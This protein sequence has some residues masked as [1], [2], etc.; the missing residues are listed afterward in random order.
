MDV[1]ELRNR[2]IGD[3]RDYVESFM[4]IR[5]ERIRERVDL[6]LTQGALWPEPRIGLN[7]AF[8]PG[9]TVDELVAEGLLHPDSAKAFQVG[10][11]AANPFG[12]PI[13]FHRHQ[14]AA[15]REARAGHNYVLTTGTGSGKSLSY[16]VPIVDHVLREGSGGGIKAVVV[17]P[18]NALANSQLGELEKF[19]TFGF[20][21][22]NQP[23]TFR[24]YT[25][26][27]NE[28]ERSEILRDPPDILLTNYVMLELIL[29]R[30]YDRRLVDA[31]RE[32]RF[33]VFDE[34]HT[35]RGRQGADVA[36]LIRR[37]RKASGSRHIQYVGTSA[38]LSSEGT[39]AQQRQAIS[40]MASQLF[41]A[42]V[43][44]SSVIGETL[45]R[46][47]EP[48]DPGDAGFVRALRQRVASGD[49][50]PE[51]PVDFIAD[52][53]SRWIESTVG[54]EE[55]EGRLVRVTP[56]AIRGTCGAAKELSQL[57]DVDEERCA[58]AIEQQLM[59]G[60]HVQRR[61]FPVF[62]FRLHQFISR[63]DTVHA[64][65]EAGAIR[66]LT[67]NP[68]RFVPGHRD[69]ILLPLAFLPSVRPGLLR[70]RTRPA[71]RPDDPGRGR[72]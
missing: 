12:T 58:T 45:V 63:G 59:T 55:L 4:R 50:P 11:R 29:T 24:R 70:R 54:V 68:Q 20:P 31:M 30:V 16:I 46:V 13:E 72:H 5:D 9:G 51:Q 49:P 8:E 37:V 17:Y 23:A 36:L 44:P 33:L 15:I 53:L 38:T 19:L 52:P 10:K 48:G 1:F 65:P 43:K 47:T 18:M 21:T 56:R 26:Q 22:G 14:V 57:I 35:Y 32:L 66:H 25:G 62:A 71:R 42:E 34:L 41:G 28:E 69:R 2:L 60:Y 27:E 61:G 67:P 39:L 64:S 40:D 3:Y 6:A 7:P